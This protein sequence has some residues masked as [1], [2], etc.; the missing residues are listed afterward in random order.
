MNRMD[1]TNRL[2]LQLSHTS[3]GWFGA[4]GTAARW[5]RLVLSTL[6]LPADSIHHD[7]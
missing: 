3:T 6:P 4:L 2:R 7:K 5:F 1:A